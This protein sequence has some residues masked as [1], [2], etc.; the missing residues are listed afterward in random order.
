MYLIYTFNLNFSSRRIRS[1]GCASMGLC[2]V[3]C[4]FTDAYQCDGLK[5][6]DAA[7]GVVIVREAGGYVCDSSGK[8]GFN[9]VPNQN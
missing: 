3:A 9:D 4:G 7:A 5:P 1:F 6:W 8:I 2:Y